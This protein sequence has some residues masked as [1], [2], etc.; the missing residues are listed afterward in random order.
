VR[1][2][3]AASHLDLFER[4]AGFPPPAQAARRRASNEV[5]TCRRQRGRTR[6]SRRARASRRLS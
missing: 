6:R 3:G 2:S 5:A 4:P 1:L